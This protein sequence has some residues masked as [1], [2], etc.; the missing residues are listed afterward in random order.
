MKKIISITVLLCVVTFMLS[1][2]GGG[3]KD[4]SQDTTSDEIRWAEDRFENLIYQYPDT[5]QKI[6]FEPR[7]GAE[8]V[9]Y[10]I[11]TEEGHFCGFTVEIMETTPGDFDEF[12]PEVFLQKYFPDHY[13]E[14]S[15][16]E[17]GDEENGKEIARYNGNPVFGRGVEDLSDAEG[18]FK[19]AEY[20]L[21]Y[22]ILDEGNNK[23]FV[24][25]VSVY[26]TDDFYPGTYDYFGWDFC[27]KL[28]FDTEAAKAADIANEDNSILDAEGT[29]YEP[30]ALVL[31]NYPQYEIPAYYLTVTGAEFFRHDGKEAVRIIYDIKCMDASDNKMWQAYEYFDLSAAQDGEELTKTWEYESYEKDPGYDGTNPEVL[32]DMANYVYDNEYS[33]NRRCVIREGYSVRTAEEFLCDW[34]G[35]PITLRVTLPIYNYNLIFYDQND[36]LIVELSRNCVK[37]VTFNPSDLPCKEKNKQWMTKVEN[38]SWTAGLSEEGDIFADDSRYTGHVKLGDAEFVDVDGETHMLLHLEYTNKGKEENSIFELLSIPV[39]KSGMADGKPHFWVMQDGVSLNLVESDITKHG[40]DQLVGNGKTEE[41][42]LEYIVRTDSPI[43][44][45]VNYDMFNG[46]QFEGKAAGK[47][48]RP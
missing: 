16:E 3:S 22:L 18:D 9:A 36:P 19:N 42:V 32:I 7:D 45:E 40:Q 31:G 48:Y 10:G 1:A 43:E 2:C 13:E 27:C 26:D 14:Y 17:L 33:N 28:A 44:V 37:E 21:E 11:S 39:W 23:S 20:M 29:M 8:G 34:Q 30:L 41:Y 5:M 38:P 4:K 6:S 46:G 15:I 35:G 25:I 47:V 12:E 24:Y